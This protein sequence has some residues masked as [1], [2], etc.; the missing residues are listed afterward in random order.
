[1]R[2]LSLVPPHARSLYRRDEL[3]TTVQTVVAVVLSF[4]IMQL[5]PLE[6]VTWAVFSALFVIQ[7]SVGGTV[8]TALWRTA[9]A[10]SGAAL[11]V[12][13][14]ALIGSDHIVMVLSV[15]VVIMSLLTIRW[16]SLSYGLVTVS[17]IAVTPD[18]G[19]IEE[20]LEKSIA[21]TIGSACAVLASMIAFPLSAR[22][23]AANE[24]GDALC[25]A[26]SFIDVAADRLI[27]RS[28]EHAGVEQT[29]AIDTLQKA[30][31]FLDWDQMKAARRWMSKRTAFPLSRPLLNRASELGYSIALINQLTA[32]N[33]SYGP[34]ED[35]TR[36]IRLVT[37]SIRDGLHLLGGTLRNPSADVD[38]SLSWDGS[39]D[40]EGAVDGLFEHS[41]MRDQ[42]EQLM[43]L[44]WAMHSVMTCMDSLAEEIN[45]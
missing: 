13:L 16:P 15:G 3:R 27:N 22:R 4:F 29:K 28:H 44:K 37:E 34:T 25:S 36:T 20:A 19:L 14:I 21:V 30:T 40:F 32:I 31:L 42:R 8:G 33:L 2:L 35:E 39:K 12:F 7:A 26:A 45:G 38:I 17:I 41:R 1:M 18:I 24:L 5:L 43:A 10:F 11:A 9:G 6:T 23:R